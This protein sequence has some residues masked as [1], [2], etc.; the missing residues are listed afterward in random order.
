MGVAVFQFCFTGLFISDHLFFQNL[1]LRGCTCPFSVCC[2]SGLDNVAFR[3]CDKLWD[4]PL[5]LCTGPRCKCQGVPRFGLA[6]VKSSPLSDRPHRKHHNHDIC[7]VMEKP[8]SRK[9]HKKSRNGCLPCK[10]RHVKVSSRRLLHFFSIHLVR[11]IMFWLLKK[12]IPEKPCLF[13]VFSTNTHIPALGGIR[14]IGKQLQG[15]CK[16]IDS[17]LQTPN[18]SASSTSIKYL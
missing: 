17:A 14:R 3:Y 2:A 6:L 4:L 13:F 15:D 18:S 5:V 7:S 10:T 11:S 12:A 1:I 9:P 16:M 8:K